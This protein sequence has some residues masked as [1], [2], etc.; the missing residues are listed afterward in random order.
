MMKRIWAGTA[1]EAGLA[2]RRD[3]EALL[4]EAGLAALVG[5]GVPVG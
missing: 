4:F 1:V 5:G 2:R 3:D